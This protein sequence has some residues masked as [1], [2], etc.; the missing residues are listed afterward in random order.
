M[1]REAE[2]HKTKSWLVGDP[3]LGEHRR[4]TR[5]TLFFAPPVADAAHG[6]TQIKLSLPLGTK[7]HPSLS[8]QGTTTPPAPL[9]E[10]E[11]AFRQRPLRRSLR[12]N[13]SR[14][15]GTVRLRRG[16]SLSE[17]QAPFSPA[18]CLQEAVVM[19]TDLLAKTPVPCLSVLLPNA[20]PPGGILP[21]GPQRRAASA[22]ATGSLTCTSR[23]RRRRR[24]RISRDLT[25]ARTW[26]P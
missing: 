25:P 14:H 6:E 2:G 19:N 9:P 4:Q 26:D 5:K 18:R 3:T 21:V 12:P 16:H 17:Q 22:G 11:R 23:G 10:G 7:R 8:S 1:G 13:S 24:S 20:E 15:N